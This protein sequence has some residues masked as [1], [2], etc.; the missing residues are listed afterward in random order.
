NIQECPICKNQ[1]LQAFIRCEDY[2]VSHET[3]EVVRCVNCTL[4]ITSPRPDIDKLGR[5]YQSD[6]YISHSGKSP[7]G[8]GF[9]YKIARSFSLNWKKKTIHQHKTNGS[10]LDFGC[11]TGE[12]LSSMGQSGWEVAGVEPSPAARLKAE[13]LTRQKV[14]SAL[15]NIPQKKFDVITAWHVIEH[16]P[17]LI[18]T[19][20]QLTGLLKKDGIIFI[21]VPNYQSPDADSYQNHW[22]GF[23]VPRHLW[24]F[25]KSSM[26]TL[27]Q[28][29]GLKL[30]DI[31]PMKLDAYYVSML[32]EKYRNTNKIGL[33]TLFRGFISG[34]QSNVKARKNLNH[35]SLIYVSKV[36]EA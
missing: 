6:E 19:S 22:A 31:I 24:H 7:G 5:Y 10:V 13:G 26:T 12:F 25:S 27:L 33:G 28:S 1:N 8:I 36:H 30:I 35:S 15:E 3:F 23:D 29:A 9:L 20:R 34:L 11:G 2:T 4:A 32:S 18:E 16:V 21:A 14:Y 17:N